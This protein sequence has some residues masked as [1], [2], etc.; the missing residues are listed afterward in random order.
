MPKLIIDDQEIVVPEGTKVIEAAERL[1]IMIPR[2]CYHPALGS[3]GACRVCAVKFLEGPH[4]GV[5][6][7]CMVEVKEGMVVSTKD[8]EAVKFRKYVIEWLMLNHPLD[9]PVCD[10][11]GHCLLQDETVSGGHGVRRYIGKK[12]TYFD[13]DLGPFI[14]HEMNRCIHC[15]RC[16]RFYQEF[17]GYRDL[18][19][20]Q[21]ANREYFG[22]FESGRLE[23]PFSGN[24]IDVCPTG[25]YTDKPTRFK[26]RRWN[27]ERGPS[28][29]L[30]CSLGCNTTGNA[31]YREV[32]R[33][34]ARFND[35][36]NGH[37]ICDRGRFGFDFANHPDRP[38]RARVGDQEVA[39]KEGIQAAADKLEQI[40]R[41]GGAESI[42]CVGSARCSLETQASL[43]RLCRLSNWPRPWFFV[44]SSSMK[45]VKSAVARLDERLSVS[46]RQIEDADFVLTLGADPVNEAPML[47]LAM[48]QAQ[49][50]GATVAVVDPRPVFL[51]FPFSHL[52]VGPGRIDLCAAAIVKSAVKDERAR[53]LSRNAARFQESLP[54]DYQWHP[55]L[56]G[57]IEELTQKLGS[58]KRPVIVC[59]TDIVR[60]STPALAANLA[61]LLHQITEG[62][63]LF[64][65]LPGPNAFG[66]GLFSSTQDQT[67]VIETI[68]TG[69]VKA[70]VL[71]E[72][73]L[74]WL[75]RDRP[76]LD[77]AMEKVECLIVLDYLPSA[78][79]ARADVV[80]PTTTLFERN[81]SSFLNQE[82]RF[83]KT[84]PIHRGGTPLW[85]ISGGKHPP[86]TFLND[87][88]GGEP[89]AAYEVL[90]EI[91]AALSNKS[92]EA[93]LKDLWA[94]L[95]EEHPVFKRSSSSWDGD[96]FVPPEVS[97]DLF[98]TSEIGESRPRE[99]GME[100]VLT[101]WTFGT[102]ELSSY[103][104]YA[105]EGET[106]PEFFLHPHDAARCHLAD[107]D[108]VALQFDEGELVLQL[109]INS[110]MATGMI[111]VP[112]H[113]RVKW[114]KLK[115]W[116]AIVPDDHIRKA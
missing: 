46:M 15:F 75:Y 51:P 9:C 64:Y 92:D 82:G 31:R 39:W 103:S 97:N 60:E 27:F 77:Q 41:E 100:L 72:Q 50:K 26:G 59:G 28:I 91:Y 112:R 29:C 70:L 1:G 85:Q 24:L 98:S 4:K 115:Q 71:V 20:L 76:R 84:P 23:S 2:F 10:E 67:S 44:E 36:V 25:V 114:Q 81:A 14:Q 54:E 18:G 80:L 49:R 56:Q 106:T 13:Q 52:A 101:E 21:I 38:R 111:V 108:K 40:G 43:T 58:S 6:M 95:A 48:R 35:R 45:K 16:R 93:L 19:V 74:F 53:G 3:V 7:S 102:E 8:E 63:G 11:G 99:A 90:G 55:G 22:R 65:L 87:I 78:S 94:W 66:A 32:L 89:K 37:F 83:Q 68:E 113:R 73:D 88:P 34:E 104:R 109:G 57:Q 33:Q 105:R 69:K 62:T 47:A 12:R 110:N 107:G 17:A 30:H 5:D 86:R 79:A 96:R 61:N 116:P 42:L